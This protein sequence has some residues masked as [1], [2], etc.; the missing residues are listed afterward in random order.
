M[1]REQR[2]GALQKSKFYFLSTCCNVP[3]HY[4]IKHTMM[5]EFFDEFMINLNAPAHNVLNRIMLRTYF[6]I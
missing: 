1:V 4:L 5:D 3:P 2:W 6:G